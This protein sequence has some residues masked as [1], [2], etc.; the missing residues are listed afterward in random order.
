MPPPRPPLES[1]L[2]DSK[3]FYHVVSHVAKMHFSRESN[4][5]KISCQPL[6]INKKHFS[7]KTEQEK[8]K[9]Q[10]PGS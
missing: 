4:Q 5:T 3:E 6:K 2:G 10:N 9:F 8:T 1:P 7:V